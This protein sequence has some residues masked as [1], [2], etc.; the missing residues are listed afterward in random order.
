LANWHFE[1]NYL[2]ATNTYNGTPSN[3]PVFVQGYVGQAISFANNSNQMVS[4]S[5]IPLLNQ[6]FSI[7]AWVYPIGLTNLFHD[8]ICGLCPT[9]TNDD[10]LHMTFFKNGTSYTQYMGFYGDDVNSDAPAITVKNWIHVAFTF[11]S[12]TRTV[13]LYRNGVLLRSGTTAQQLK[14]KNGSFQIGSVPML[15]PSITTLMVRICSKLRRELSI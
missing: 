2:D 7:N 1:N 3:G 11:D 10:C 12:T 8:A 13:S 4:T 15:V 5:Y 14:A 6:S 9:A